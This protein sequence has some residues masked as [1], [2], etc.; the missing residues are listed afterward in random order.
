[1]FQI[2]NSPGRR[3][4][5]LR[6]PL[7]G[8]VATVLL[9]IGL[10]VGVMPAASADAATG[11]LKGAVNKTVTRKIGP[12]RLSSVADVVFTVPAALPTMLSIQLRSS[13]ASKGYRATALVGAD[14][15][16][17]A[18][19][20]RVRSSRAKALRAAV[21][22][23]FKVAPGQQLEVRAAV[24]GKR[25]V[26]VY[27]SAW[28]VGAAAPTQWLM[29]QT[30]SSK[31]RITTAGKTRIAVHLPAGAATT[32]VSYQAWTKKTTAAAQARI[33]VVGESSQAAGS[34]DPTTPTT[35]GSGYG[36]PSGT[37]LTKKSGDL[38]I[39]TPGA[40][41]SNIDLDGYIWV[42][43]DNV[44][45]KNSILRG[46]PAPT[47]NRALVMSWN[48][49]KNLKILN[50]TLVARYPSPNTEGVSGSNYTASGLDISKVVDAVKV[51]GSNVT[52][53]NSWL[54]DGYYQA[55][56]AGTPDGQ[57][58][59]DAVQ[60]EGGGNIVIS[61]NKMD[62][63]HNTA[64]MI[65]QNASL[66]TGVLMDSNQLSGGQCTVNMAEKGKGPLQGVKLR[67]NKFGLNL[68]SGWLC[69]LIYPKTT[70]LE[71]TSNTW[72]S[73][74]SLITAR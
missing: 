18:A 38:I 3:G 35:G 25:K 23:D 68:V 62:G 11:S 49:A 40:V 73:S 29:S 66:I 27:L 54:H 17:S 31:K 52:V 4:A 65:T 2:L 61:G 64:I 43:A 20:Y 74:G 47:S 58:H 26:K 12:S 59:N 36:V 37:T 69:P 70:T 67:S 57:T 10:S 41:I 8:R 19:V 42:K 71:L 51:T 45:I 16:V 55:T 39:T 24:T 22:L 32:T 7:I 50:S 34:P 14:G 5:S 9:A 1:M 6:F 13:K 21:P 72:L 30:D 48:G 56:G 60:I 46:G 15:S 44:T 53:E 63:Y 28:K 33:G